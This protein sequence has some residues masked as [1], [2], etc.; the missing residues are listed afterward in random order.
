MFKRLL[1]TYITIMIL[2]ANLFSMVVY[3]APIDNTQNL[4]QVSES[5]TEGSVLNFKSKS[6][7][8]MDNASG[9][10]LLESNSHERLPIASITKVM[11][12]LLVMEAIDSGKIS[13]E[14]KILVSEHAYS[15]GGS[16][17]YLAPGEEFTVHEYLKAV[18]IHSA[19]DASVVLAEKVAGSE[20]AFV[21]MMNDKAR[22][23]G[24]KDT[25]FLDCSG[26]TDEGHYSSAHDIAI[27]SREL[28]QKHPE[29]LEYTKIWHDT[30]RNGTFSLDNTNK[31]IREY[32]GTVGLKTG[33]TKKAGFC[34]AA[35]VFR[36]N[37]QLISVILGGPDGDTRFSESKKI[38][39]Y[40]F[41]NFETTLFKRKGEDVGEIV[42]RKGLKSQVKAIYAEDVN[43]LLK[44]GTKDNIIE[45][46][47]IEDK[48]TAPVKSGQKVG[49]AIYSVEGREVGK[50][51]IVAGG[52]VEKASFL[53][54]FFRMIL[55]WF[56]LGKK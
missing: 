53:R 30:F 55:E 51:T 36:G 9:T 3:S 54:L 18:A 49:E 11:T 29:I 28:I 32:E 10:I 42:V 41:A 14:D 21:A 33:S 31:L 2:V 25:N 47:N 8:V 4:P 22:E 38:L 37:L 13:Y 17:V 27:M 35:V 19:N 5:L 40:G 46:L 24:M 20:E 6:A 1:L 45:K 34:L 23:L 43:L 15:M 16:Q 56:G 48:I 52:S 26:L 44:K 50:V 39:D 12:M 7:L